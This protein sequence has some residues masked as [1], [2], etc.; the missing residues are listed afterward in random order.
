[1]NHTLKSITLAAAASLAVT[2]YAGEKEVLDLLVKKGT[3]TA[4]ERGKLLE[5]SKAK[6]SASG[7][8]RVFPKEDATKRLTF[9]GYIQTQ[10]ESF[11]YEDDLAASKYVSGKK[12]DFTN[13]SGFLMRRLYL[14][15]L[16][17]VGEGL[18][19]N[20]VYDM[21]GNTSSSIDRAMA[22]IATSWGTID[23]GYRKVAWGYEESTLSSLFKASSSK[24]LTVE[25]GI[26]NRYWNEQENGTRLGFGAHHTGIHYTSPAN[27]Q[28]LE[29]GFSVVNA[30]QGFTFKSTGAQS[31]SNNDI[32]LFGNVVFNWK[33][34]DFQKYAVGVNL[35]QSSYWTNS[36]TSN[37]RGHLTGYN[38][39][40]QA[41]MGN[42]TVYGELLSTKLDELASGID[43]KPKG[44]NATVACKF[45]D[46]WEGVARYTYLDTDGRGQKIGDG[47]RDFVKQSSSSTK[48]YSLP[49]TDAKFDKSNSIFLGVNYYF[50]LSAAGSPVYGPNA[51]FQVGYEMANF[52]DGLV[53]NTAANKPLS[54]LNGATFQTDAQVNTIRAQ[55]QVAF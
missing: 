47:V 51:K 39:F 20:V 4:E 25:R 16:A 3:I 21:S 19:A 28:G 49:F 5:E 13:Q 55:F 10:Y 34:S 38:P 37:V 54:G 9:S 46:N 50:T 52:T 53:T 22:S 41:M 30:A 23:A 33:V 6:A 1:M 32:A 7:V 26:T 14:E 12:P 18:S 36:K 17:D 24:L 15:M 8:D 11:S 27:P 40:V 35:G 42:F 45:S 2:A 48:D 44:Y 31:G 29:Y 43:Y